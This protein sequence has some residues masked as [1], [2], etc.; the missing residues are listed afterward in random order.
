[1][2][3]RL[4]VMECRGGEVCRKCQQAQGQRE[5]GR[6]KTQ[7]W[8]AKWHAA[9]SPH[10]QILL[11]SLLKGYLHAALNLWGSK[12]VYKLPPQNPRERF[13]SICERSPN[14]VL[15]GLFRHHL[16]RCSMIWLVTVLRLISR[17]QEG[18]WQVMHFLTH[19]HL[20]RHVTVWMQSRVSRWGN[21]HHTLLY[22]SY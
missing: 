4:C 12:M 20:W 9:L 13:P 16:P 11:L 19:S 10:L 8:Q 5:K 17:F 3:A 15:L 14:G 21:M 2:S 7:N 22:F 6:L 1:M 18:C